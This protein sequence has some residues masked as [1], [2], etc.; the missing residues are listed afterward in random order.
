M[1]CVSKPYNC[2]FSEPYNS[3]ILKT[4]HFFIKPY[5]CFITKIDLEVKTI[6]MFCVSKPYKFLI[7]DKLT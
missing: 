5:K 1:F 6:Q 2:L 3:K 7:F 4:S